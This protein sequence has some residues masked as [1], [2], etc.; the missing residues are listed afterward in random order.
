MRT[1]PAHLV[2]A[3]VAVLVAMTGCDSPTP[4]AQPSP[5]PEPAPAAIT[6]VVP[7][8]TETAA[9][10]TPSPSPAAATV[11]ASA[12][13]TA[14]VASAYI[15]YSTQGFDSLTATSW[16][17]DVT[18]SPPAAK[19]SGELLVDGQRA[20]TGFD[21]NAGR[22]RIENADG[23]REDMG[24]AVGVLDPPR[25]LDPKT[26]LSALLSAAS[27]V[28]S[29]PGPADVEGTA[30]VRIRAQLPV[31][32]GAILLPVEA[33]TETGPLPVT[34]WIDPAGKI[35]RQLILT[36]SGGSATLRL[37]PIPN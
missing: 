29:D 24:A 16:A 37:D 36:T 33:I 19:G 5:T 21:V 12:T 8:A 35:L 30:M 14:A 20:P 22:L 1:P 25:L 15:R 4:E 23:T 17:A 28:E 26:G 18:A 2:A 31:E 10:P 6:D 7:V 34:L 32:A 27:G 9:L 3:A 11:T 13:A